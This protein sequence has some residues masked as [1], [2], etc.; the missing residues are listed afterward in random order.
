MPDCQGFDCREAF[1]R[2]D[3]FMD[4]ELTEE[5]MAAVKTHLHKCTECADEF[6]FEESFLNCVKEKLGHIELPP[7]LLARVRECLKNE[8]GD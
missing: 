2:L 4:R 7:D 5:E 8:C 3:D 6:N 1:R